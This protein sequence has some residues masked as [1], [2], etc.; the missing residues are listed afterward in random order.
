MKSLDRDQDLKNK[1]IKDQII[2][3]RNQ[4]KDKYHQS[5]EGILKDLETEDAEKD[6]D[7]PDKGELGQEKE[8]KEEVDLDHQEI[9]EK[10]QEIIA[11][12]ITIQDKIKVKTT[13][14]TL[15]DLLKL[16]HSLEEHQMF[17]YKKIRAKLTRSR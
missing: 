2:I 15:L 9:E 5:K 1:D 11:I 13:I 4:Q 3:E 16:I 8:G 14:K 12:G 10:G 17:K 6:Q 7:H